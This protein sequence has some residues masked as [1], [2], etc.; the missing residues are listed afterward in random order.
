MNL[1]RVTK[2]ERNMNHLSRTILRCTG[3]AILVVG[4]LALLPSTAQAQE[5]LHG[6]QI[7]KGCGQPVSNCNSDADCDDGLFCNGAEICATPSATEP[8]NH[9]TIR[10]TNVDEFG[11]SVTL[12][13]LDDVIAIGPT[14]F[15]PRITAIT[16]NAPLGDTTCTVNLV[17][18]DLVDGVQ[19]VLG[20]GDIAFF[21]SDEY[22]IQ[23][24][25]PSFTDQATV[26]STDNCES[27]APDCNPGR[28]QNQASSNTVVVNNCGPGTPP[29]CPAPLTCHLQGVC[30]EATDACTDPL[31]AASVPCGTDT[32]GNDCT[33]PGCTATGECVQNHTLDP[34]S[35]ACGPDTDA[36]DCTTPGCTAT[37]E[38]SQTH[39]EVAASTPCGTDTDGV[40]C[41]IP[42][43]VAGGICS[44]THIPCPGDEIC[45]TPGFWGTHGGEEKASSN[46]ITLDILAAYGGTLVVCGNPITNTDLCSQN[47]ALEAIC[48]S[49]KGDSRLQLGRQLTAAALN[50]AITKVTNPD[51]GACEFNGA[52]AGPVCD[53]I[54]IGAVWQACNDAC[55]TGTTALV[56][57]DG[58][59]G[60][61]DVSVS[62]IGAIDCFNNGGVI[63]PTDGSC[64]EATGVS[65]H[66]RELCADFVPPGAA[67][68]P[69]ECNDSRK[70][71]VTIFG[72]LS[73]CTDTCP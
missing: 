22:L 2:G 69:R 15:F 62:C 38:C 50:C 59:A 24:Q 48:V 66:D 30:D 56:D 42:G 55:P 54:S 61:P 65:C 29:G 14:Q 67:G 37:G 12:E 41:T 25:D 72:D 63:D 19:C 18:G 57:L 23:P 33:A 43:C 20:N 71:C 11:D 32:D 70:N 1:D 49:P 9:C 13:S 31:E 5:P 44:Q 53:G 28:N 16:D 21:F 10:V 17:L 40:A 52:L 6:V 73:D 26:L 60:T 27:Q 47:S 34:V 68:S 35:T 39:T 51:T 8:T 7:L 58:D 45:R 36:T 4:V 46:N 64:D 3:L